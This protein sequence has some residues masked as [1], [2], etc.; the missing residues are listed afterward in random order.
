LLPT[1]SVIIPSYNCAAFLPETIESVLRQT[2][3]DFEI[4]LV[5]DGSTDRT[6]DIVRPY[7]SRVTYIHQQ[8]KGLP[9]A[10]NTGI[11]AA[12]GEFIALLDADDTWVP[13][14][15]ERQ[16][17]RFADADVGIVYSDFS[18]RYSDGRFKPSYLVE[19]PLASEG[20]VLEKYIQSR[21]LFPSTMILRRACFEEFGGFDE[22]MLAAEDIELFTRI[23][24]RWK[25]ALVNEPLVIRYEGEHN[26][27]SN[28]GKMSRYTILA[29]QKVLRKQTDLTRS[30]REAI[31][32]ELGRQHWWRGYAALDEGDQNQA[33]QSFTN[34]IRCD[35][36]NFRSAAPLIAASFLPGPAF[37]FL[38]NRK[39]AK[40]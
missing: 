33:R 37:R 13:N 16:M 1:I 22:E 29:L 32:R 24:S 7:L 10:R 23:C 35:S 12:Q 39:R 38:R 5:D 18:V 20:L 8:N 17:P 28:Q 25:V 3:S 34:A 2:Y 14:K 26:I 4:V 30:D 9:G 27:T 31:S 19:R 11:R 21:F 40:K 15:L 6:A 36:S